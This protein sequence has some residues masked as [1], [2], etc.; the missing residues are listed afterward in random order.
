VPLLVGGGI[1]TARQAAERLQ[2]GADV[3]VVGNAVEHD[4]GLIR[5]IQAAVAK[6][7]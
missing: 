1:R 2:A 4:P 5:E 3:L 7:C 6:A